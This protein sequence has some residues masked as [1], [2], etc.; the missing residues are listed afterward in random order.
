M[1]ADAVLLSFIPVMVI[2]SVALLVAASR[3][4][5]VAPPVL[6]EGKGPAQ[7]TR[8]VRRSVV[9]ASTAAAPSLPPPNT[10]IRPGIS[11]AGTALAC[12]GVA[13]FFG[14]L[15]GVYL[16]TRA[17]TR[18][19][20]GNWF[21]GDSTI[22]LAQPNV[23]ALTLI[24][25]SFTIA[26]SAYA[27]GIDD[28]RNTYLSLGITMVLGVAYI[29]QAFYMLDKTG[30]ALNVDGGGAHPSAVLLNVVGVSHIALV[31]VALIFALLVT[32]RAFGGGYSSQDREG[33]RSV[34]LFFHVT[35]AIYMVIW[36]S[37]YIT[38]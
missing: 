38:K 2:V 26:W 17:T 27:I 37:V 10:P 4:R 34:A 9:P 25:A 14:G 16:S 32:I 31:A 33:V 20:T 28:R 36:Y 13:L 23:M 24:M 35:V 8:V 22:D 7:R 1:D 11:L 19:Q 5:D 18:S 15:I 21:P 30:L 29:N 3:S 6:D 12:F